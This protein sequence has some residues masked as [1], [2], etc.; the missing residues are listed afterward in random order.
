MKKGFT[1]VELLVVVL[2][3]GIL[4]AVALPQYKKAVAKARVARIL[5]LFRSIVDAKEVYFMDNSTYA[6]S[7]DITTLDVVIPQECKDLYGHNHYFQCGSDWLIDNNY[8]H[9]AMDYCPG[10]ND[11]YHPNCSTHRD[12]R[13][14][15]IM[16][17]SDKADAGA[18]YCSVMNDSKLGKQICDNLLG[19]TSATNKYP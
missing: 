10:H 2:I 12:F 4:A 18:V 13:L 16:S 6:G 9:P 17:H 3:I 1:L 7:D 8:D 11:G 14:V 15:A 19:F 5:P